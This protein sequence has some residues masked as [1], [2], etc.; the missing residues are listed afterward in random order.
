MALQ[1]MSMLFLQSVLT[2][3]QLVVELRQ[4]MKDLPLYSGHFLNILCELLI[5]YKESLQLLYKG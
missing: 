5:G 3:W 2:V 4:L 1:D